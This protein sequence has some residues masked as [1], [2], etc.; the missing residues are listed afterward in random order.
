MKKTLLVLLLCLCVALLTACQGTEP[1]HFDYYDNNQNP[2]GAWPQGNQNNTSDNQSQ[3]GSIDFDSGDYDP[4]SEEGLGDDLFFNDVPPSVPDPVPTQAPVFRSQFA[5]ATPVPIDPI[6]KPTPTPVP[7][8]TFTYQVYDA[9]NLGLSFEGPVGWVADASA[10]DAYVIYNPDPSM[11]Y[12]ATLTLRAVPVN[13]DYSESNLR[14]EVLSMLDSIGG[15]GFSE[16]NRSNTATRTLL[17]ANGVYANYT[18]T[19]TGGTQVAGRV[20][21]AYKDRV[22]YTVHIT[23]PA[24]YTDTYKDGVYKKLRDTIKITK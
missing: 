15:S 21:A 23:Y 19:L 24:A 6:D 4:A 5:G 2:Q 18:G 11:D 20:Q 16:Y 17:G 10:S 7:P 22:L 13:V 1:Q 14:S 3:G 9:T 8:L 12:M